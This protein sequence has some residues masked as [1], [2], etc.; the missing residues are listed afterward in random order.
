MASLS[1]SLARYRSGQSMSG[2][3]GLERLEVKVKR[4]GYLRM[5][6][7]EQLIPS[8]VYHRRYFTLSLSLS[9]TDQGKIHCSCQFRLT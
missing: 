1:V 8:T 5:A 7:R 3:K 6:A 2:N 4:Q 9:D